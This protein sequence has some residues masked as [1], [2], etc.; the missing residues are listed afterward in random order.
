MTTT[1]ER[2]VL[3]FR[4]LQGDLIRLSIP[5]P[6]LSITPT[7]TESAMNAIITAGKVQTNSGTPHTIHSAK[8]YHTERTRLIG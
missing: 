3:R 8:I 7:E 2:L 6:K 4:S 5:R 1:N